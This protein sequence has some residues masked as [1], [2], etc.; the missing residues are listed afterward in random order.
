MTDLQKAV[1]TVSEA[2]HVPAGG[3]VLAGVVVE[4][5]VVQEVAFK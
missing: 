5:F 4:V 3:R 2:S 1:C